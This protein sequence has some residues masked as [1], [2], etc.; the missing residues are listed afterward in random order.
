MLNKVSMTI[1]AVFISVTLSGCYNIGPTEVGVKTNKTFLGGKGVQDE[2][3]DAGATKFYIPFLTEWTS[4]DFSQQKLVMSASTTSGDR[5]GR[6]DM[7]FKTIDG[8][9]I[10]LDVT[11]TYVIDRDRAPF[12]L[13]NVARTDEEI[14][15]LIVRTIARSKPRDI[16]GEL[17]T[18]EFY[19]AVERSAKADEAKT[20]LNEILEPYGIIVDEVNTG[21]YRFNP[22]YQAAIEEKKLADQMVEKNKSATKAAEEE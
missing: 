7:R 9:D 1:I 17:E 5:M 15:E 4:F 10:S 22:E 19:D 8:N 11:I 2:L 3:G 13:Q 14:K 12:I 20:R 21:D 18:E 16:F 6:D